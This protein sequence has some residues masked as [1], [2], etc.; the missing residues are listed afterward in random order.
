M[1]ARANGIGT[2]D[3]NATLEAGQHDALSR[4]YLGS[5]NIVL[6]VNSVFGALQLHSLGMSHGGFDFLP[7]LTA[8]SCKSLLIKVKRVSPH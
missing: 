6:Y 3:A 2:R 8:N 5:V 7:G 1:F 4:V